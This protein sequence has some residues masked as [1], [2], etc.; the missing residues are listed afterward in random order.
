MPRWEAHT[1]GGLFRRQPS[2][3]RRFTRAAT[4]QDEDDAVDGSSIVS[5]ESYRSS[6]GGENSPRTSWYSNELPVDVDNVGPSP[7]GWRL[8]E[9][10]SADSG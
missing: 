9:I 4:R 7:H 1:R 6:G 10:C 5:Y 2:K 8:P 3:L